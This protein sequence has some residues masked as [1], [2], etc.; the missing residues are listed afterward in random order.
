M[1]K[2]L[3]FRIGI[4]LLLLVPLFSFGQSPS[5]GTAANFVLF[6]SVGAVTNT[7]N[8]QLTGNIGTN[9]GACTG[10]GNFNGVLHHADATSAQ[11][12]VDLTSAYNQLNNSVATFFPSAVMGNGQTFTAGVYA[13]SSAA[14]F[15]GTLMMDA[16]NNPN[17][18]FIIQIAGALS[19][20]PNAQVILVNGAKSSNLFWKVEGL[21]DI[22]G[23]ANLK[24]TFIANNAA[25]NMNSGVVI[26]GRALSTTGAVSSNH[27]VS[28]LPNSLG[29]PSLTGPV[30]PNLNSTLAYSLFSSNGAVSNTGLTVVAGDVG[31][32]LGTTTGYLPAN[33]SGTIHINPDS[34]TGVAASDLAVVYTYLNTLPYDIELMLP[35]QF[36][37]DLVLTPHTYLLNAATV[38]TD[39]LYF[40][41]QNN[42]NAVFVIQINGAL[43]TSVNA[44][45]I[46]L[47][48]AQARNVFWKVD[49]AVSI[50]T[51]SQ[52]KGTVVC[53]NGA[54][55]LLQGV[56]LEGRAMTTT[57]A[58]ST[59]GDTITMPVDLSTAPPTA[60]SQAFCIG[61]TVSSLIATGT[62][63]KWYAAMTGGIA[64]AHTA[65][66]TTSTY[67]ASQTLNSLE[68]T[69]TPVVVTI[70]NE[71]TPAFTPVSAICSGV[72]VSALPLISLN[73]IS[74]TWGP[75]LNN[76]A[77]TIYTFTPATGQCATSTSLTIT[78]NTTT[79]PSANDQSLC[80][81]TTVSG[82]V[83][84]GTA[85]K[86]YNNAVGGISLTDATPLIAGIYY[87]EQTINGCSSTAR[88]AVTVTLSNTS[89]G[90]IGEIMGASNV[91]GII[92]TA[93]SV[94]AIPGASQYIWTFPAGISPVSSQ[95][96]LVTVN[97]DSL[98]ENGAI[99]VEAY[100]VCGYSANT[101]SIMLSKIFI[102]GEIAGS[103][104]SCGISTAIYSVATVAGTTF[105]WTTPTGVA[106]LS[107][108]GSSTIQVSFNNTFVSGTPISVQATNNC[109][110]SVSRRI[111]I[112]NAQKPISIN[113]LQHVCG[114]STTSYSTPSIPG[115]SFNWTTPANMSII[116]GQGTNIIAV[117]ISNGFDHGNLAV[118]AADSCGTSE[119][120]LFAV[121]KTKAPR[122]IAG[123][124]SLCG[125]VK[126]TYDTSG[127]LLNSVA[128][129]TTYSIP[130]V[131]GAVN[132]SWNVPSGVTI[133]SGQGTTA[134]I[135][136]FDIANFPNGTIS[137]TATTACGT[138]EP[139]F[140]DVKRS[141]VKIDGL[142]NV[143]AVTSTTYSVPNAV[144]SNFVWAVPSWMTIISGQ[145]TS[146]ISVNLANIANKETLIL[147]YISSCGAN[148]SISLNIGCNELTKIASDQC[149]TTLATVNTIIR[150]DNLVYVAENYIQGIT[151]YKFRIT[152]GANTNYVE[153]TN[154]KFKITSM[155]NWNYATNYTIAVALQIGGTYKDY[156]SS[157]T[158]ST[159]AFTLADL[160]TT[161][162]NN[163]FC[164]ATLS[165][166][167]TKIAADYLTNA[168]SYR[169][170]ITSNGNTILYDSPTYNFRLT[171]IVSGATYNTQY[172]IRVA[173][174]I[175]S[176]YNNYG[177]TCF[178][179]TPVLTAAAIPLIKIN[180]NYCGTTLA[181]FASKIPSEV[182]T[183]ATGY[184]FEITSNGTT[185]VYDSPVYN[186]K[187]SQT[188]T[189]IALNTLYSVRVAAVFNG[190]YG[191][192][193]ISCDIT[194]PANGITVKSGLNS[195]NEFS[196][197]PYP[198][199]FDNTFAL[200]V[201]GSQETINIS[202]YDMMGKLVETK[203]VNSTEVE[204]VA[205]GQNYA[206]G[207]YN[208]LVAQ[209]E[210]SKVIRLV[211]K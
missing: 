126:N 199:P 168:S 112:Y 159:P 177:A 142:T 59:V 78:V 172:S 123:P 184:R 92:S 144:G 201:N 209:G 187:L 64:L 81:G 30:A 77:S 2:F 101:A 55:S 176:V 205:L 193:G 151:K 130:T 86:W 96:N 94:V 97:V 4:V 141:A 51:N 34:S 21:I 32:N 169:F 129:Q 88:K 185:V 73:T 167:N 83:A 180:A 110:I 127:N 7:G 179:S 162:I 68:S 115:T 17:A 47:N 75:T 90:N 87:A 114:A 106:I 207:I 80:P 113:G 116:S 27:I 140:L 108:Q 200:K 95:G 85:I 49:G 26:E 191:N 69:R 60:V 133:L 29:T 11:C 122:A 79:S 3:F 206:T 12:V 139:T 121:S 135:V 102:V 155:P 203:E 204:N 210:N 44:K 166:L 134:I 156:G 124:K 137:V 163:V 208:V 136:S 111:V 147:N 161:K 16:Q 43:T 40:D 182:L 13:V 165:F 158:V 72:S 48:G 164:G 33:V 190:I 84:A 56:Q 18:V 146:T 104:T 196:A 50:N 66:L 157:C 131:L 42:S 181:S 41:A 23:S 100:G 31:T 173:A 24:G 20:A 25:I 119:A 109:G 202:V 154:G 10:F 71:T 192:Y 145:N 8:S 152:S 117:T 15:T 120:L 5:L 70:N 63:I 132:Y 46:L 57:G 74:G 65:L 150:S 52:F 19:I 183:Q 186:F 188:G 103:S 35:A 91:C 174:L 148:E 45:V 197:V 149:G 171:D 53:N 99:T 6:S 82:L 143:C 54:I 194:S 178:V 105:N 37:N 28:F 62:A 170:E 9:A 153:S 107:G 138:S 98:F 125:L 67:Y 198:N 195:D 189:T 175:N 38:L 89:L 39:N 61:T 160:P 14:S 76:T 93:Y 128:G 118:T 1:K 211:R 58:L 36:G 22:G